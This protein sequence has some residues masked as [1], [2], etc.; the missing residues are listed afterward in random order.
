MLRFLA[1]LFVLAAPVLAQDLESI[2]NKEAGKGLRE[3][4]V[5]GVG[6]AVGSLSAA[7]GFLGNPEVK[8][9]LP[10]ALE[11][12]ER[13]LR[14]LGM[15]RQADELVTTMNRAAESAVVEAKPILLDGIRK[16]TLADA[17]GILTGP[18]DSATRYFRKSSGDAI[19]KKF[20]P[21][22]KAATARVKLAE[23][24]KRFAGPAAEFGLLEA[25][26]A[27][28]DLYIAHKTVDG[29]FLMIAKQEKAI[30]ADPVGQ[31]SKLLQK[32][33]GALKF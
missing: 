6:Q 28:L 2:S 9:P 25:K 14:R 10:P 20:L 19:V 29:L 26:D 32:V 24:Y 8:I 16:M 12:V 11:K 5:Q 3:A 27:D 30:R 1:C 21:K 7:D 17:K 13:T 15:G 22:V 23:D 31:S 4:L 33:F 18:E